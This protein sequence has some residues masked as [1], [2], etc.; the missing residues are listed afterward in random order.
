M[1]LKLH[2]DT[3]IERIRKDRSKTAERYDEII[4][5]RMLLMDVLDTVEVGDE[6]FDPMGGLRQRIEQQA[7][8]WGLKGDCV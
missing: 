5:L 6:F 2:T 7:K 1:S 8:K 3:A 4:R